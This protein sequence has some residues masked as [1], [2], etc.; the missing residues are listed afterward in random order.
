MER[1]QRDTRQDRAITSEEDGSEATDTKPEEPQTP[2]AFQTFRNLL[3]KA[4]RSQQPVTSR[5]E[6]S[7]D[8]SKSLFLLVAVSI[9]LLLVFFGLFSNPKSRTHLPGET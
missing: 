3:D 2:G 1:E 9:A 6:L 4:R 7:R 5:R 8:K